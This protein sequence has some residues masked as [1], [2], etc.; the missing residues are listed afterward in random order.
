MPPSLVPKGRLPQPWTCSPTRH[1]APEHQASLDCFYAE[2]STQWRSRSRLNPAP[3]GF[4]PAKARR[5]AA[6]SRSVAANQVVDDVAGLL[7]GL[8]WLQTSDSETSDVSGT[9]EALVCWMN[10]PFWTSYPLDLALTI[11]RLHAEHRV[12]DMPFSV[13]SIVVTANFLPSQN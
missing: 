7:L 5:P 4:R 8:L 1:P 11:Y 6:R 10:N 13:N 2:R 9:P 3:S 12:Y